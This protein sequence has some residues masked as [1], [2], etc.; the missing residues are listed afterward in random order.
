M[1]K[2]WPKTRLEKSSKRMK[3][4]CLMGGLSATSRKEYR[5]MFRQ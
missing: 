4:E 2:D 5:L 3:K 1:G